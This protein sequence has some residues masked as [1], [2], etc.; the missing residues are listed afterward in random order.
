MTHIINVNMLLDWFFMYLLL[1]SSVLNET[2]KNF[3]AA[4]NVYA[5]NNNNTSNKI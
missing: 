1:F 3:L 2:S 5:N 4:L